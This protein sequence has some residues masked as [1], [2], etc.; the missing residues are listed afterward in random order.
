MSE[1][2]LVIETSGRGGGI[3]VVE[4]DRWWEA[5]LDP[6]RRHNRDLA[7]TVAGLLAEAGRTPAEV[8]G[9]VVSRGPGSYTGLRV[10]MMSARA[11]AYASGC[12]FVAVPTFAVLAEQTPAEAEQVDVIAD[13]LQGQ[14]Y[15]QRFRCN[16]GLWQDDSPLAIIS[17]K[18]WLTGRDPT[19]WVTGPGL[20]LYERELPPGTRCVPAEDR[21]PGLRALWRVSQRMIPA[22][23]AEILT[24]E[25]LYLRGSSAEE[26]AARESGP[27]KD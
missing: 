10:G 13:A 17:A 24:L 11:F 9:V 25:P 6:A 19:A 8:A 16:E 3:G 14:I 5:R 21:D 26:K 1:P 15:H 18:E 20:A 7:P 12:R 2:W 22:S 27:R 4:G 23:R